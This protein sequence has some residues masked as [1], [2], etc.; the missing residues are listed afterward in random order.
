M[1]KFGRGR[2]G[3]TFS[4]LSCHASQGSPVVRSG[5]GYVLHPSVDNVGIEIGPTGP[6]D[7][8]ELAD[9]LRWQ[10]E[11]DHHPRLDRVERLLQIRQEPDN[12]RNTIC[13][14]YDHGEAPTGEVLLRCC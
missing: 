9:S 6:A 5:A 2:A 14:Q 1:G 3:S 10:R 12:V 7:L 13:R 11:L 8:P 4:W